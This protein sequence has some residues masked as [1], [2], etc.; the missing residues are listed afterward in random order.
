MDAKSNDPSLT[1]KANT[2][3]SKDRSF[4][5][6]HNLY[7]GCQVG[8]GFCKNCTGSLHELGW[9]GRLQH[10]PTRVV[11]DL[12][13][14]LEP[15]F[16]KSRFGIVELGGFKLYF[17]LNYTPQSSPTLSKITFRADLTEVLK[18]MKAAFNVP[19]NW[20]VKAWNCVDLV[21][22]FFVAFVK[23]E[24]TK[25]SWMCLNVIFV[26]YIFSLIGFVFLLSIV[27]HVPL[28]KFSSVSSFGF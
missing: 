22:F 19:Q 17:K 25:F 7:C 6:H 26:L 16:D 23:S 21:F 28:I 11:F 10:E 14:T 20:E 3:T 18:L 12:N 5:Q 2:Q 27:F 1:L 8:A 15:R 24:V 13:A 4:C 9:G